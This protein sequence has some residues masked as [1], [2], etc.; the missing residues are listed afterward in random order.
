MWLPAVSQH[1]SYHKDGGEGASKNVEPGSLI[2]LDL[3]CVSNQRSPAS[4]ESLQKPRLVTQILSNR[5]CPAY[6]SLPLRSFRF[7]QKQRRS[8]SLWVV[9]AGARQDV[10]ESTWRRREWGLV[11]PW[12]STLV[13]PPPLEGTI[14]AH[15]SL[16]KPQG[17]EGQERGWMKSGCGWNKS[18]AGTNSKMTSS[19]LDWTMLSLIKENKRWGRGIMSFCFKPAGTKGPE[20]N[21]VGGGDRYKRDSWKYDKRWEL[22]VLCGRLAWEIAKEG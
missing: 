19:F 6:Q 10:Y 20:E 1:I 15:S 21:M 14:W 3:I 17:V 11:D 12:G 2:Q 7:H 16:G 9:S 22:K 13:E 5:A 18:I 8:L 4:R